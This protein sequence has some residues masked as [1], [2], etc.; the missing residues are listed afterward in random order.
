MTIIDDR[1]FE[2]YLGRQVRQ[3]RLPSLV[4]RYQTRRPIRTVGQYAHFALIRSSLSVAASRTSSPLA[5]PHMMG[6][7]PGGAP[8]G[9]ARRCDRADWFVGSR[10]P[11]P[12]QVQRDAGSSQ[13]ASGQ[14]RPTQ[15]ALSVRTQ[16]ETQNC[17]S[18]TY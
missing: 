16:R 14:E 17:A 5:A 12:I 1:P 2:S 18:P 8:L 4:E 15:L 13:A 10:Y 9:R 6:Q 11:T 3:S 7:R